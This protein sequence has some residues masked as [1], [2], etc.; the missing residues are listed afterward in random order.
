[1]GAEVI[2]VERASSD[3]VMPDVTRRGKKS[4]ALNLKS[5]E[6][7]ETLLNLVEGADAIFEGFRPGVAERPGCWSG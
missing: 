3:H 6:G 5:K 2:V 7:L 4:I 1:M